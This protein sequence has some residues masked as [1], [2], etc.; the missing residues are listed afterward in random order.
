MSHS[1]RR[2]LVVS[3][4]LL[5]GLA[6]AGGALA[7][8]ATPFG[9]GRAEPGINPSSF[10]PL[11]GIASYIAVKQAEIYRLFASSLREAA[12]DPRAIWTITGLCFLYGIF[13]AAGP[14]H[15]KAVISSYLF[16]TGETLKRGVVISFA[17]SFVQG[18]AAVAL[19]GIFALVFRATA[20]RIDEASRYAEIASYGLIVLIGLVLLAR[21]LGE[22]WPRPALAGAGGV[23]VGHLADGTCCA[24]PVADPRLLQGKFDLR[25]AALAVMAVGA[26]PCT[27]AIL[28][29]VFALAQHVFW[30]GVLGVAAIS[31]GT[32]LTVGVLASLAV[33]AQTLAVRLA[34]RRSGLSIAV[35]HL[36]GIGGALFVLLFG[37][38]LFSAS[39]ISG[40]QA[41]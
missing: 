33:G 31:L 11:A 36:F 28:T 16:A 25:S 8:G 13:H 32:G 19:V 21:K 7:Q 14:G 27:G 5:A 29:L 12:H 6:A 2:C 4:A 38:T 18:A 15:G 41:G 26:R 10:G 9:V 20:A 30:I 24:G 34:A 22:L 3:L 35:N 23:P 40:P 17:S 39:L 1:R 37:L